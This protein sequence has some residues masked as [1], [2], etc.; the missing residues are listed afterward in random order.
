MRLVDVADELAAAVRV[1]SRHRLGAIVIWNGPILI[2]VGVVLDALV[3][4]Q[5][6]VALFVSDRLNQ[7]H[8]GAVVIRGDRV[9]RAAVPISWAKVVARAP[10]LASG[11][12]IGVD[13]DT[14]QIRTVDS[15]GRVEVVE[16][17]QL[18]DAIHP[19]G[20]EPRR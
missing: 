12:A 10:E 15:V 4:R 18:A 13:D 6:L 17:D 8:G 7:L 3:S 5:L 19:Y 20:L 14:G 16:S 11:V 9:E 2:T 1:L